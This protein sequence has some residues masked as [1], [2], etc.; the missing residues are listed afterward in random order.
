MPR[1]YQGSGSS[2]RRLAAFGEQL[3]GPVADLGQAGV[4]ADRA[5]QRGGVALDQFRVVGVQ[6]ER[7]LEGGPRPVVL[8]RRGATARAAASLP[9]RCRRRPSAPGAC[10]PC[11]GSSRPVAPAAA[12]RS[13][14]VFSPLGGAAGAAGGA[15]TCASTASGSSSSSWAAKR[16]PA[17]RAQSRQ[18]ASAGVGEEPPPTLQ[19]RVVVAGLEAGPAEVERGRGSRGS[20]PASR[21]TG[22]L[23]SGEYPPRRGRQRLP[24]PPT[25]RGSSA[26][27]PWLACRPRSPPACCPAPRASGPASANPPGRPVALEPGLEPGHHLLHVGLPGRSGWRSSREASGRSGSP[28]DPAPRKGPRPRSAPAT[29]PPWPRRG[30]RSPGRRRRGGALVRPVAARSRRVDNQPRRAWPR[31]A[32]SARARGPWP[33]SA[34]SWQ[35]PRSEPLARVALPRNTGQRR[36]TRQ[37]RGHQREWAGVG[38]GHVRPD[39]GVLSEQ[40]GQPLR[41]VRVEV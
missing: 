16:G 13:G 39:P 37:G 9:D 7:L 33:L 18:G 27:K 40:A 12:P 4:A 5:D 19:G 38:R 34:A 24:S 35:R 28:G 22:P 8:A 25:T 20:I 32:C 14:D 29:P 26:A 15:E 21:R 17:C 1:E 30:G 11:R 6:E 41:S 2:G 36:A 31:P 10:R 23:A 3:G